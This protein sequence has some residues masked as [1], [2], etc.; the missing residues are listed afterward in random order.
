MDDLSLSAD[1]QILSKN[2][3]QIIDYESRTSRKLNAST[4]EIIAELFKDF[5]R[6]PKEDTALLGAPIL[7]F[8]ALDRAL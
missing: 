2:V 7:Q 3:T 1:I 8:P 6:I 4:C 5:V